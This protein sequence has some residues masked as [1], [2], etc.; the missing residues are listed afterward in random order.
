MKLV[1]LDITDTGRYL[2]ITDLENIFDIYTDK[3]N[4]AVFNVNES[5]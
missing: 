3:R 4:N 1:D 2:K 5:S